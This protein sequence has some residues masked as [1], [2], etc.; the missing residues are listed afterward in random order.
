MFYSEFIVLL[1]IIIFYV[2]QISI[3]KKSFHVFMNEYILVLLLS[4]IFT[5]SE[6][7][8]L[9]VHEPSHRGRL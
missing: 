8:I 5:D 6:T 4:I 9:G 1:C 2:L 7:A 3:D